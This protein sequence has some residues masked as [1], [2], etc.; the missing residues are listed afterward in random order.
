MGALMKENLEYELNR[1]IPR[2]W[3]RVVKEFRA[4]E[5]A[6]GLNLKKASRKLKKASRKPK[7][8]SRK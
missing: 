6:L 8:A 3:N 4:Q 2:V 7:K 1:M 5:K